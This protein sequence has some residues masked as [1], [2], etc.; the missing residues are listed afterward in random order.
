M[1]LKDKY[2]SADLSQ[3]EFELKIVCYYCEVQLKS[4]L[5]FLKNLKEFRGIMLKQYSWILN[6]FFILIIS[7]F[8]AKIS[9]VYLGKALEIKKSIGVLKSPEVSQELTTV[10][11]QEDYDIIVEKNIFDSSE[12]QQES[13][14]ESGDQESAYIPGSEAVKTS[15]NIKVLALLVIG[16]G[17]DKRSSATIDTGGAGGIDVYGVGD[18]KSFSPGTRLIQ[19]KPD[20][21]EFVRSNRLEYAELIQDTGESIFGPP[22]PL[23]QTQVASKSIPAVGETITKSTEGKFTIDQKELDNAI[24]NM[25]KLFTEIRA[26]PNFQDGKVAGMKILSVKPGSVFAKLGLKRGDILNRI[27]GIELDVRKGFEIFNQL[28]D[29]KNISL[30]LVRGG[31]NQTVEYEIR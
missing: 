1:I 24:Q 10:K 28:K 20:R 25:D 27:N 7:F 3:G 26:V 18:E 19:V 9:N 4:V 21:I 6:I 14:S 23:G 2:L 16:E 5:E 15:L 11:N 17:K 8:A 31:A 13:D 22:K 30:D 12:V 29:Q